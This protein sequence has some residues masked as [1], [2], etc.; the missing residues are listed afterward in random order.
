MSYQTEAKEALAGGHPPHFAWQTPWSRTGLGGQKA[1]GQ[2]GQAR[3]SQTAQSYWSPWQRY[4]PV[5]E[6]EMVAEMWNHCCRDRDMRN[7]AQQSKVERGQEIDG[8]E[9]LMYR[10]RLMLAG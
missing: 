4:C 3:S 9:M 5:H 6:L 1:L 7:D 8:V 10:P 2:S